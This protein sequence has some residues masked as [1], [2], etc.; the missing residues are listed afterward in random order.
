MYRAPMESLS[1]Y[2]ELAEPL[3]D[4]YPSVDQD[5]WHGVAQMALHSS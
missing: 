3:G 4:M 1:I 5:A 2:I